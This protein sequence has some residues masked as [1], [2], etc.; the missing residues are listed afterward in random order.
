MV[1]RIAA[2]WVHFGGRTAYVRRALSLAA[3]QGHPHGSDAPGRLHHRR[4][5][6]RRAPHRAAQ[7]SGAAAGE[8]HRGLCLLHLADCLF[9]AA[10]AA[11][12]A[13]ID[14]DLPRQPAAHTRR[15]LRR[16]DPARRQW[17]ELVDQSR[18]DR[19]RHRPVPR[20]A[21][22]ARRQMKNRTL[23]AMAVVILVLGALELFQFRLLQPLENRL[24]DRFVRSQAA[25]LAPDPDIVLVDI[26]EKSL[27]NMQKEAG[28]W[29]WPRVVH[30]DLVE[31]LA[32]QKPRAIVFDLMFT[33]ADQFPPR[34]LP[35]EHWRTGLITC[36]EDDD[37]VGRRYLLRE[38]IH[39]WQIPSLPARVA[40]D[41]GFPVPDA[42][43]IV[44]A[45]RGQARAFPRVSYSDLYEDFNRSQRTRPPDEFTGKIVII[46][47]GATGLQDLRVTPLD[48]L[49]P[50][51]EIL[52]TAI[53]NLKNGRAMRYAPTWWPAL[54]GAL[55]IFLIYLGFK[56]NVDA[57]VTGGA[58]AAATC[59]LLFIS[60]VLVGRLVLLPVL[61]PL[62]AA[63]TFYL[64][65]ALTEYL[66]E[67]RAR[68]EAVALFSRFVNPHVVKQLIERG[69]IE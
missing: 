20:A 53:E 27:A 40:F 69:G 5:R 55:L 4:R 32:T 62:A 30:A 10:D 35:R 25:R 1:V 50:G 21:R 2:H 51:A 56:R 45:W 29:P 63:W 24:L 11:P 9:R 49:H 28:R 54:A 3:V 18:R 8:G 52:G 17:R 65:A 23:P 61:T 34:V 38:V 15:A 60:W 26:D 16:R 68:R 31:G 7:R 46:G 44:L 22:S 67:R 58:L 19:R 41:L 59:V 66:R 33:E 39:G 42:D 12:A 43:D 14:R 6:D 37:G 57:R 47:T 48:S 36:S 13:Q 64:A